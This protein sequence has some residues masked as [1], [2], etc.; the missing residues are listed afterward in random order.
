MM[1]RRLRRRV[2]VRQLAGF[3]VAAVGVASLGGTVGDVRAAPA[4]M[5]ASRGTRIL[6]A[7]DVDEIRDKIAQQPWALDAFAALK[8]AADGLVQ[9]R[10]PTPDRGGGWFHAGGAEYEISRVHSRLADGTRT[11]GLVYRLTDDPAYAQAGRQILLE[12][13]ARYRGY[14]AHDQY[15]RTGPKAYNPGKATSQGLDEGIWLAALAFGHDLLRDTFSDADRDT[16]ATGLLRPAAELL[17][18][19]NVGRHNHQTYYNLGIGLV[20]FALDEPLYVEH[21]VQ[22]PGSGLL[23]QLSP[24]ASSTSDGFWYEGSVHYHFYALEGILGL[25]EAAQRNGFEPYAAPSLR[26]AFDFPLAY[27]DAN[28][29]LPAFND[30]PPASLYEANRAR[31]YEIGYRRFGD[32][33]YAA[34]LAKAGRGSSYHGLLYGVPSLPETEAFAPGQGESAL[35]A[36]RAIPVLRAGPPDTRIQVAVNGMW[37]V[38][39]HTQ[40]SQLEIEVSASGVG[41]LV[42]APASIK[43]ADPLHEGWY[44]QTVSHS[45]VIVDGKS[46]GRG[47]AP[48]LVAFHAGTLFSLA[49]LRTRSAY[50]G[51]VLDRTILLMDAGPI[52]LFLVS[53]PGASTL[54]WALHHA[55]ALTAELPMLP[56][57]APPLAGYRELEEVSEGHTDGEWRARWSRPDGL[58]STLWVA[59]AAGT[60]VLGG[61]GRIGAP[62]QNNAPEP[63]SALIVRRESASTAFVSALLPNDDGSATVSQLLALRDGSPVP[64]EDA[65]SLRITTARGTYE[66]VL[67]PGAG[68]YTVDGRDVAGG[69]AEVTLRTGAGVQSERA[70]LT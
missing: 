13:A 68:S 55:G 38:G 19:Y 45:T 17:M 42:P 11:L 70:A 46:Q 8:R 24:G 32:P 12:Y 48:E 37:Y 58:S 4:R 49:R 63:V 60:T 26:G 47:Q 39:G 18:A 67:T 52:D 23:Y 44:R 16:I 51:A 2:L 30:G 53:A 36:D 29:S 43:Y 65:V 33:R 5:Q 35:L 27:A 62:D 6:L 10:P 61:L 28:G 56:R 34:L 21:A 50:L 9:S 64:A 31:L 14:E 40:P 69:T 59:G 22:K 1:T 25:A 41:R 54:D 3:A 7:S 15:G 57:L 66:V 20:G